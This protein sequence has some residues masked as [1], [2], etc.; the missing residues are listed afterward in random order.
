M[1]LVLREFRVRV[2]FVVD[3]ADSR[4]NFIFYVARDENE[5]FLLSG[6]VPEVVLISQ[7]HIDAKLPVNEHKHQK[8]E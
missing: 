5:C 2:V 1:Q 6:V 3:V 7:R 4:F 8:K